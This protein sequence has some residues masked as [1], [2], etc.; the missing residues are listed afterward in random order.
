[1]ERARG[2]LADGFPD[3]AELD[4][5]RAVALSPGSSPARALLAEI[6]AAL[7][8]RLRRELLGVA[9]RPRARVSARELA[10]MRLPVRDRYLLSRCDGRRTVAELVGAAPLRELEVLKALRSFVESELVEMR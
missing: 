4:V 9:L 5:S 10:R 8:D 3:E 7:S 6:E 2:L 1:M